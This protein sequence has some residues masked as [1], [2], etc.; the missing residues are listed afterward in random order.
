LQ[1]V[2]FFTLF[3]PSVQKQKTKGKMAL[4]D[5]GPT[6][7][8]VS[9]DGAAPVDNRIHTLRCSARSPK[10][11]PG[12]PR[13]LRRPRRRHEEE[14]EEEVAD[15]LARCGGCPVGL[16][17]AGVRALGGRGT[18][19]LEQRPSPKRMQYITPRGLHNPTA[20]SFAPTLL[21]ST[22]GPWASTVY[23]S[24][25]RSGKTNGNDKVE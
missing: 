6:V 15:R 2:L 3:L 8:K 1:G 11:C 9:A 18:P 13:R 25:P 5:L 20:V 24:W 19:S 12:R 14:E 10:S 21:G 16:A 23:F 4:G 17:L 7:V 22:F